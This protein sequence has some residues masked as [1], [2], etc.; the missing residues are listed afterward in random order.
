MNPGGHDIVRPLLEQLLMEDEGD[1][2]VVAFGSWVQGGLSECGSNVD[3][4]GAPSQE[5]PEAAST[6]LSEVSQGGS[7]SSGSKACPV[8]HRV[9]RKSEM[10]QPCGHNQWVKQ[11]KKRGKLVLECMVCKVLWKTYPEFHTRCPDFLKGQCPNGEACE[12]PHV[13]SRGSDEAKRMK[14]VNT[15]RILAGESFDF[16]SGGAGERE[17]GEEEPTQS[18]QDA[19]SGGGGGADGSGPGSG[20]E[21][22]TPASGLGLSMSNATSNTTTSLPASA[23]S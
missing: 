19:G 4:T 7:A 9:P 8:K 3:K 11:M 18:V 6:D 5:A 14:V 21:A 10:V 20:D 1:D 17:L 15:L 12:H 16:G 2:D 13:Y 22:A 23:A